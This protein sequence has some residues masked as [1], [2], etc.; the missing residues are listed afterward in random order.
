MWAQSSRSAAREW[1]RR[2]TVSCCGRRAFSGGTRNDSSGALGQPALGAIGCGRRAR[3]GPGYPAWTGQTAQEH[4]GNGGDGAA[5]HS[6]GRRHPPGC[7][8][9]R[10]RLGRARPAL[11]PPAGHRPGHERRSGARPPCALG[12]PSPSTRDIP[13]RIWPGARS[14]SPRGAAVRGRRT[15]HFLFRRCTRVFRSSLRCFFLAILLRRFLMTEPTTPPSLVVLRTGGHACARPALAGW[16]HANVF[17]R[18]RL[19][20]PSQPGI[21]SQR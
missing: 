19:R 13:A 8:R 2:S 1:P 12:R 14:R 4:A 7:G 11:A 15:G 9:R 20:L 21:L 3:C 6:C 17:T 10:A 16:A 18:Q 5:A